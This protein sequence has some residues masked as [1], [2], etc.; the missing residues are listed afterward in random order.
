MRNE[1]KLIILS[2][3]SGCGKGTVLKEWLA[4]RDDTVVSVSV[5]SRDPRP[6]EVDGVH[7][8]F[9]T[10]EKVEEMAANG[11]LL[12]CAEFS[13]NMYGTP[14]PPIYAWRAEGKNVLLE[15]EVQ[16]AEMVMQKCPDALTIFIVPP[17]FEELEHRLRG[18]GTESE[19][20]VAKR[21]ATARDE[22]PAAKLYDYVICNDTVQDA[23]ARLDA[24]VNGEMKL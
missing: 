3:P 13:G 14:L 11:E 4:S 21:L 10:R 2:G 1:G 18:R 12:E 20:S 17:S 16:G 5:T 9:L 19:E 23:V 15:I 7:Y 22:L 8:H 6:G 24:L